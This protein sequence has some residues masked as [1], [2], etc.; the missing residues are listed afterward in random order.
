MLEPQTR[1]TKDQWPDNI[2]SGFITFC[3]S[4]VYQGGFILRDASHGIPVL[5]S[6]HAE[7]FNYPG[8]TEDITRRL[9]ACWN[10]FVGTPI[11]EIE[12]VAAENA[13]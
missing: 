12:A 2:C 1:F 7:T 13:T 6:V 9:V 8:Q 3:P 4:S 11:E 5:G 10:A